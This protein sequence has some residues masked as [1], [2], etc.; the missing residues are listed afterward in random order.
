LD[1]PAWWS[2]TGPHSHFA[3][4]VGLARRYPPDISPFYAISDFQAPQAWVDLAQLTGSEGTAVLFCKDLEYPSDWNDVGGGLGVQMTGEDVFGEFDAATVEL[5]NA[6][7]PDMLAL[8][9]R[10]EPGPFAPDTIKLGGYI[11]IREKGELIAMAGCRLNPAGWR[12]ISA[13]CTDEK[14]RGKGLGARLVMAVAA[15]IRAEGQIPFLHAAQT[16][17][18]AIRLYETLG[19]RHRTNPTWALIQP[20]RNE[21]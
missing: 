15:A 13:V 10:T 1:N 16:N 18:N 5:T 11:G 7:V 2:L 14:H 12:E 20:P 19:F 4:G 9:A 8:V 3:E 21:D 6:D 17:V